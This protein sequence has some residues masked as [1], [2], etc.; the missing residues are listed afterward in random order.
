[1]IKVIEMLE[2]DLEALKVLPKPLFCLP[3]ATVPETLEDS[4]HGISSSSKPSQFGR[5]AYS[6]SL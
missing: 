5:H 4:R 6:L 2:G 1:M 3:T